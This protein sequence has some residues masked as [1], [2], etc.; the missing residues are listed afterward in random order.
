MKTTL[1]VLF[2]F[3]FLLLSA[4]AFPQL[5][6]SAFTQTGS[7]YSVSSVT[8][9]QCLGINPANLGWK[10]NAHNWNLGMVETGMSIYSEPMTKKQLNTDIFGKEAV[11]FTPNVEGQATPPSDR[12]TAIHDFTNARL[13]GNATVTLFGISFQ[14]AD[15]GG[16]AFTVKSKLQWNSKLNDKASDFLFLGYYDDYFNI[17]KDPD[18]WYGQAKDPQLTSE[19]YAGSNMEH[20]WYNEYALGYGRQIAQNENFSFYAG[21]ALKFLQGYGMLYVDI[22]DKNTA[23][24]YQALCPLYDVDYDDNKTP[25]EMDPDGGLMTAGMGFGIVLGMS[26]LIKNKFR[27]AVAVND[28]GSIKWDGNVYVGHNP[29]VWKVK[30]GGLSS[31]NVFSEAGD[32]ISDNSNVGAWEG[33]ENKTVGLPT[34]LRAGASYR[35]DEEWEL[36]AD[37]YYCLK[38]DVP[39]GYDQPLFG[40]GARFDP[41][42]WIQLSAGFVSGGNMGWNIPFGVTFRPVNNNQT[43]WE[44][45]AATRDLLTLFKKSTEL[46][47]PTLSWCFGFLRFSFGYPETEKRFLDE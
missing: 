15:F 11:K 20:L 26:F 46:N 23:V 33:K 16:I 39:G 18:G 1:K 27:L 38:D 44:I 19:L 14:K 37:F 32:I 22:P 42:H 29:D 6:Y 10:R 47:D 35:I 5:E 40:L 30:S 41:D 34:N 17:V 28:I 4:Y 43:S 7:A 36:G 21:L 31:Y 2:I 9:Y 13:L 8:D 24:G 45:G 3:L 25:S 12:L